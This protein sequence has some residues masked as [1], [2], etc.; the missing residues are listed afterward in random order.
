MRFLGRF[1][2]TCIFFVLL[3]GCC[4]PDIIYLPEPETKCI[5]KP[6]PLF[7]PGEMLKGRVTGLKNCLPFVASAYAYVSDDS[8]HLIGLGINT[9]EDWGAFYANKEIIGLGVRA[10]SIGTWPFLKNLPHLDYIYYSVFQ[11][12]DVFEDLYWIDTA[13][14]NVMHLSSIDTTKDEIV[15]WFDCRFI[16]APPGS[17]R[18]PDTLIYNDCNFIAHE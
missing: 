3:F 9:Y 2:I 16:V 13:Y 1:I 8:S 15:G 7:H 17:G 12:H 5:A 6:A 18:Q 4:E 11:D 14:S 10:D